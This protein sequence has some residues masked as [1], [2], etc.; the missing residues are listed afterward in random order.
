M[1][2]FASSTSTTDHIKAAIAELTF[3]QTMSTKL[4]EF[5]QRLTLLEIY[6]QF[7]Y[8]FHSQPPST[9]SFEK[10]VVGTVP[11]SSTEDGATEFEP[12]FVC[13]D[14]KV[15]SFMEELLN[16]ISSQ[17]TVVE[18]QTMESEVHG[19]DG[20]KFALGSNEK[21]VFGRGCEFSNYNGTLSC[22]QV[23]HVP[24][25]IFNQFGHACA[26]VSLN[27]LLSVVVHYGYVAALHDMLLD[28]RDMTLFERGVESY[29]SAMVASKRRLAVFV[30]WTAAKPSEL[31]RDKPWDPGGS[32]RTRNTLRT[33]CF[34]KIQGML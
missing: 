9:P 20:S 12:S 18:N 24:S 6:Y 28:H 16:L 17:G 22:H 32:G 21:S 7:S 2:A 33:R 3:D 25:S 27:N 13:L 34:W 23:S 26:V 10:T 30:L 15:P 11:Q 4:D 5:L 19:E 29:G 14:K 8:V 1:V 31:R